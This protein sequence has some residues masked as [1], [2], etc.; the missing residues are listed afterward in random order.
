MK[1]EVAVLVIVETSDPTLFPENLD[2]STAKATAA[3]R[4]AAVKALARVQ[5]VVVVMHPDE[6]RIMCQTHNEVLGRMSE[7]ERRVLF[8]PADYVPPTRE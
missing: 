2:V 1:R 5:R 7:G 8:P 3:L 6:A 4:R